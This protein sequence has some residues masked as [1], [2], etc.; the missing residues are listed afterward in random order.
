[1]SNC[2]KSHAAAH[3]HNHSLF[4]PM[5]MDFSKFEKSLLQ[6]EMLQMQKVLNERTIGPISSGQP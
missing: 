4:I 6:K 3:N 5:E 2:W 1:M